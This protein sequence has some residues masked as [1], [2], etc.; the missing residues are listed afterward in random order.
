MRSNFCIACGSFGDLDD[1]YLVPRVLGGPDDSANLITLCR[2][3][4]GKVHGAPWT[5]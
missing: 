2:A 3:C 5:K 4:H 1:H